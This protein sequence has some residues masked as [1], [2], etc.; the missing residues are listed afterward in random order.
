MNRIER[1]IIAGSSGARPG[2]A[3]CKPGRPENNV[4]MLGGSTALYKTPQQ[5]NASRSRRVNGLAIL[6]NQGNRISRIEEKLNFLEQNQALYSS[7]LNNRV[8]KNNNSIELV[9]GDYKKQMKL[10]KEYI[11]KLEAKI[12][13]MDQ[14][15][16]YIP[17][18]PPESK[19]IE[20]LEQ[21][22]VLNPESA[23]DTKPIENLENIT[24]EIVEN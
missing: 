17:V 14:K 9:N 19:P 6:Q 12:E 13:N 2:A 4:G 20:N 24:L 10:M 21:E 15:K 1:R 5:R 23:A 3:V 8:T 11:K 16:V 22:K 7:D 18:S